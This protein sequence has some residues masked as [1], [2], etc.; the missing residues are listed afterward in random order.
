[1]NL[2]EQAPHEAEA[3]GFFAG[4]DKLDSAGQHRHFT[5]AQLPGKD[6]GGR[7]H[8]G[9]VGGY[10]PA[11]LVEAGIAENDFRFLGVLISDSIGDELGDSFDVLGA[12]SSDLD[13]HDDD[14]LCEPLHAAAS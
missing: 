2:V 14:A 7:Q 9:T 13:L 3:L 11:T 6:R 12:G 1:M 4:C 10:K 5:E 8:L